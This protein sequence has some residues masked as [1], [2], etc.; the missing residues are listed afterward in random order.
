MDEV[1]AGVEIVPE[2]LGGLAAHGIGDVHVVGIYECIREVD[3]IGEYAAAHCLDDEQYSLVATISRRW[4][5][6]F[7]SPLSLVRYCLLSLNGAVIHCILCSAPPLAT[8]TERGDWMSYRAYLYILSK[9]V[10]QVFNSQYL[11][12]N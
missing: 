1:D 8:M 11:T 12:R 5:H 3:D 10:V 6:H 4:R 7:L 9:F 2:V